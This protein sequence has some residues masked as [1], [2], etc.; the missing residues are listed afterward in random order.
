MTTAIRLQ[1]LSHSRQIS[2]HSFMMPSWQ[3]SHAAAQSLQAATDPKWAYFAIG[4]LRAIRV[5]VRAQNARQSI[6]AL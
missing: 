3:S 4:L 6:A 1:I 5:A 2:A